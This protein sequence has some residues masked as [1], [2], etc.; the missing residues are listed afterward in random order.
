MSKIK[1]IYLKT[2]NS[3]RELLK[4]YPL[5]I[6]FVVLATLFGTFAFDFLDVEVYQKIFFFLATQS[7][8]MF[9]AECAF[10]SDIKRITAYVVTAI[11]TSAFVYL[12][13]SDVKEIV[14]EQILYLYFAYIL[15]LP[16]IGIYSVLLNSKLSFKKYLFNVFVNV[17]KSLITYVILALGISLICGIFIL[18]IFD[19]E[20]GEIILK[21]NI[22]IFGIYYIPSLI[23]AFTDTSSKDESSFIKGIVKYVLLPLITIA[24]VVIYMYIIKIFALKQIPSNVIFRILLSLFVFSFPIWNMAEIFEENKIVYKTARALPYAFI[25]FIFLEMYSIGIR[26]AQHGITPIRYAALV[27]LFIQIIA[28]IFT[29][30]KNRKFLPHLFLAV[31]IILFVTCTTLTPHRVAR[32]SQANKILR[33]MPEG[34]SFSEISDEAKAMVKSAYMFFKYSDYSEYIPEYATKYEKEIMEYYADDD[35]TMNQ[36]EYI[37]LEG[38]Q[39]VDVTEYRR[40]TKAYMVK[41]EQKDS[42]IICKLNYLG[43]EVSTSEIQID[44]TDYL[45]DAIKMYYDTESEMLEEKLIKVDE[46]KTFQI[47]SISLSYTKETQEV[48]Y[49]DISGYLLEK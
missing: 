3:I 36:S 21:A 9:F 41:D 8:G 25:P 32:I 38:N 24:F 22:L 5:T 49:I 2:F 45:K 47:L 19:G 28:L 30:I 16:L 12:Q 18:L 46:N 4:E 11:I 43:N 20:S 35:Y 34:T 42:R 40:L 23:K 1:E 39:T 27:V 13:W 37:Y 29:L 44:M 6:I 33:N 31:A 14:M 17:L 48:N 7:L 10:K 15:I 26:I